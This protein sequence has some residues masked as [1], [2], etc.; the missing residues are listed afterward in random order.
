MLITKNYIKDK[1]VFVSWH[2]I[3]ARLWNVDI[4]NFSSF[5]NLRQ[6]WII[7]VLFFVSL[8][9]PASYFLRN[10]LKEIFNFKIDNPKC[11]HLHFF[12]KR[13]KGTV[14]NQTCPNMKD[15]SKLRQQFFFYPPHLHPLHP[16]QGYIYYKINFSPKLENYWKLLLNYILIQY[17]W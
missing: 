3:Q 10:L 14:V 11:L 2:V 5:F 9:K 1:I 13:D 17:I 7:K 6:C 15:H 16:K 8:H 4:R 12:K